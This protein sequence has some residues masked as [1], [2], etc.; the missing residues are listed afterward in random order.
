MFHPDH[1]MEIVSSVVITPEFPTIQVLWTAWCTGHGPGA[2]GVDWRDSTDWHGLVAEALQPILTHVRD[3]S[4]CGMILAT[5]KGNIA[6]IE[7]WMAASRQGKRIDPVP[8]LLSDS[9]NL[10]A[11]KF[12]F[13]GPCYVV[14]TACTSGLTALIEAGELLAGGMV[15]EVVV[16]AAETITDFT[17]SGFQALKALT[18]TACRPFDRNRDGLALGSAAAA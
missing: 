10:V 2:K 9:L 7:A 14:S 4:H 11:R 13:G 15:S 12:G 17:C 6:K 5:A 18:K 1:A 3:P 8:E 16:V